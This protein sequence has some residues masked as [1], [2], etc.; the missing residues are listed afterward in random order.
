MTVADMFDPLSSRAVTSHRVQHSWIHGIFLFSR[1]IWN[2]L[3]SRLYVYN[4]YI[5]R[6]MCAYT[7]IYIYTLYT[8][9]RQVPRFM[10][11]GL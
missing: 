3:P 9:I 7:Y 8:N 11:V 2:G 6:Q 5:Y 10:F 4:I 1:N